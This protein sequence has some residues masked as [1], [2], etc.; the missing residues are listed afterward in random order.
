MNVRDILTAGAR[1]KQKFPNTADANARL[2]NLYKKYESVLRRAGVTWDKFE[3]GV[4][5]W[6]RRL[7]LLA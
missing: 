6:A 4:D 5:L 1:I 3:K 2:Q 7:D